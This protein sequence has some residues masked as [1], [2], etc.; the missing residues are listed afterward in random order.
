MKTTFTVVL[1]QL[2]TQGS[3]G[4]WTVVAVTSP[5]IVVTRPGP[6]DRTA[7]P[8]RVAGQAHTFEGNVT[9]EVREDGMLAGQTLGRGAVTGGGDALRPFSGDI[10]FRSSSKPAGAGVFLERSAADGQTI[11]RA[12]VVRVRF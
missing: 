10:T 4:A 1:R 6:L 9:V 11:L 7:S 3:T 5:N 8:V 2:G 12:A